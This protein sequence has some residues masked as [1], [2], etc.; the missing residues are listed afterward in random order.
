[1]LLFYVGVKETHCSKCRFLRLM[2]YFLFSQS[3]VLKD[4]NQFLKIKINMLTILLFFCESRLF[5]FALTEILL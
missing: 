3:G 2:S 5:L 4:K 1:M